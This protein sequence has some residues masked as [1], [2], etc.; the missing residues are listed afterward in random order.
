MNTVKLSIAEQNR[1][2]RNKRVITKGIDELEIND[3]R[4]LK[5]YINVNQSGCK[6][7]SR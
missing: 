5:S 7:I 2:E 6:E 4:I 1:I 3:N